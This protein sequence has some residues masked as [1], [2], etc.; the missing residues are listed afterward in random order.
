[1]ETNAAQQEFYGLGVGPIFDVTMGAPSIFLANT[2]YKEMLSPAT[3][4][5]DLHVLVADGN[6]S[7]GKEVAANPNISGGRLSRLG[8]DRKGPVRRAANAQLW[9]GSASATVA[10]PR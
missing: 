6:W 9:V 8:L 3:P 7:I 5:E 4:S 2:A 1:M 10:R